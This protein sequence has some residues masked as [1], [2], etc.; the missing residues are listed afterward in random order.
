MRN[1]LLHGC[2]T[3]SIPAMWHPGSLFL[4]VTLTILFFPICLQFLQKFVYYFWPI[5]ILF[6]AKNLSGLLRVKYLRRLLSCNSVGERE[7]ASH[8]WPD[9]EPQE[10]WHHMKLNA[11]CLKP[12]FMISCI[13]Q[14]NTPDFYPTHKSLCCEAGP[15]NCTR[16]QIIADHGNNQTWK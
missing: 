8:L 6:P 5:Q 14:K 1:S 10:S 3:Q 7:W 11:T 16:N 13:Y 9:I 12:S 2:V 4:I 15:R